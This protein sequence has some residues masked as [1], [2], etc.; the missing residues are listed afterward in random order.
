VLDVFLLNAFVLDV[1]LLN[2]VAP[3]LIGYSTECRYAQCCSAERHSA[4]WLST[5]C[6]SAECRVVIFVSLL[7]E[8][9]RAE[10]HATIYLIKKN[11]FFKA[12]KFF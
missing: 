12:K 5:N 2:V 3:I 11:I 8:E 6:H 1:F 9:R 7:N 4:E 10:R